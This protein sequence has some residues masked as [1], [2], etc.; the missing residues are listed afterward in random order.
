MVVIKVGVMGAGSNGQRKMGNGRCEP[1]LRSLGWL[2][3]DC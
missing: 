3:A 1:A 2:A